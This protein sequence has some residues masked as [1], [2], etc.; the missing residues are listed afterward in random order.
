MEGSADYA[1]L[2]Q[3]AAHLLAQ[4]QARGGSLLQHTP[5]QIMGEMRQS[6]SVVKRPLLRGCLVTLPAGV[7]ARGF[8]LFDCMRRPRFLCRREAAIVCAATWLFL[9]SN[10]M[11]YTRCV[12]ML[13]KCVA[14]ATRAMPFRCTRR[15]IGWDPT[16][17]KDFSQQLVEEDRILQPWAHSPQA[18]W[19]QVSLDE[20][21]Q[22]RSV[23]H[24]STAHACHLILGTLAASTDSWIVN[25]DL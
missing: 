3:P 18:L 1:G 17:A 25:T 5:T 20:Q 23:H 2:G 12:W 24:A 7:A 10:H 11:P 22:Q 13:I 21:S 15:A 14:S 19:Q 16:T 8:Y 4:D 6:S 9:G